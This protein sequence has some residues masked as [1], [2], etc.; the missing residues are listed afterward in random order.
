MPVDVR[1]HPVED[2]QVGVD[3]RDGGERLA[4]GRGLLD[5]ESL[6]AQ[7]GRDG[8][9]DRALVVDDEDPGAVAVGAL[10]DAA[11]TRTVPLEPVSRLRNAVRRL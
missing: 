10:A 7:G 9:D 1:Q 11:H 6:V 8:V 2:D 4:A 3:T 5:L